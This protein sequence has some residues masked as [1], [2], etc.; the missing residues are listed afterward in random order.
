LSGSLRDKMRS[1]NKKLRYLA[2]LSKLSLEEIVAE[3][4]VLRDENDRLREA[5][6]SLRDFTVRACCGPGH[7]ASG[8]LSSMLMTIEEV[9][10]HRPPGVPASS[11][12][13]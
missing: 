3:A 2:D 5:L 12:K 4:V 6:Q 9:V 8:E 13:A 10:H 7:P 11:P 1:M